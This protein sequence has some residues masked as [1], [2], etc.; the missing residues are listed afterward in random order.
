MIVYIYGKPLSETSIIETTDEKVYEK[1]ARKEVVAYFNQIKREFP[2]CKYP[3]AIFNTSEDDKKPDWKVG[4]IYGEDGLPSE[5]LDEL[6]Y[7]WD[8]EAKKFLG[9]EYFEQIMRIKCPTDFPLPEEV[10]NIQ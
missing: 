4:I 8:D 3:I 9:K 5:I 2:Y 1:F 10:P 6:P 7:C